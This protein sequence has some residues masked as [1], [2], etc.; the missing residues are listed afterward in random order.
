MKII[1]K[2]PDSGIR[3]LICCGQ[4]SS[5]G[6]GEYLCTVCRANDLEGKNQ[7][8]F[9]TKEEFDNLVEFG[10]LDLTRIRVLADEVSLDVNLLLKEELVPPEEFI[11]LKIKID[12]MS[13]IVSELL[14]IL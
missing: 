8:G 5:F 1:T 13:D 14:G 9:V 4:P 3:C 6:N 11:K 7:E 2:R 12:S 10:K